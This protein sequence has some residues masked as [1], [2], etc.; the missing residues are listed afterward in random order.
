MVSLN[1][2]TQRKRRAARPHP[3]EVPSIMR[4]IAQQRLERFGIFDDIMRDADSYAERSQNRE[5]GTVF[6]SFFFLPFV[7]PFF[8]R[9]PG[10]RYVVFTHNWAAGAK[11]RNAV[12]KQ[13]R[14]VSS[15]S[16]RPRR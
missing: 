13:M 14:V 2:P 9:S 12:S 8:L 16:S 10:V 5:V 6:F 11:Q 3:P 7:R 15:S 4:T 1:H